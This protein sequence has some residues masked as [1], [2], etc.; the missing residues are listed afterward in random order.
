MFPELLRRTN[1]GRSMRGLI[2]SPTR[3]ARTIR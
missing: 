1:A 2:W 3:P